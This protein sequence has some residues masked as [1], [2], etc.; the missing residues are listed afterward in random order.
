MIAQKRTV[1]EIQFKRHL[2]DLAHGHHHPEEHD[3]QEATA[4]RKKPAS[5]TSRG[6]ASASRR[7]SKKK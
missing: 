6:H 5:R 1:N 7:S 4:A 2:K 3:W